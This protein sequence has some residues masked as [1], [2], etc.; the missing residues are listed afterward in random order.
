MYLTLFEINL[1]FDEDLRAKLPNASGGTS[2]ENSFKT[3]LQHSSV[4]FV[5][6]NSL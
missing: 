3:R 6:S 5:S 4:A 2:R 1:H